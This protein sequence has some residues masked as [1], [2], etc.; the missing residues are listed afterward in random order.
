MLSSSCSKWEHFFILLSFLFLIF[1]TEKQEIMRPQFVLFGDS[2]TQQ[3]FGPGG[4]GAALADSY[5]RKVPFLF[6]FLNSCGPWRKPISYLLF[7]CLDLPLFT[8]SLKRK[9][10]LDGFEEYPKSNFSK[11]DLPL[12]IWYI[13]FFFFIFAFLCFL[14]GLEENPI[15]DSYVVLICLNLF[16]IYNVY[17]IWCFWEIPTSIFF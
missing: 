1:A 12:S 8:I 5:S 15:A 9:N 3:S 4:W 13:I 7:I 16:P 10:K 6:F 14:L 11:K 17:K 2:I